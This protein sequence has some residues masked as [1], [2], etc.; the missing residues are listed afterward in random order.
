MKIYRILPKIAFFVAASALLFSIATFIKTLI[1]KQTQF[2]W[3][4]ILQIAGSALILG[5]CA[6]M[7]HLIKTNQDSQENNS[8][9]ENQ[10]HQTVPETE[11]TE[12]DK[13]SFENETDNYFYKKYGIRIYEESN[14]ENP[15]PEKN[16]K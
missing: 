13:L 5:I 16:N 9:K 8:L 2:I 10:Y 4:S 12:N 14:I 7:I 1:Q 11:T 15:D 6:V 3:L